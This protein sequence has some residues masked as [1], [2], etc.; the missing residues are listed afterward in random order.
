LLSPRSSFYLLASITISFRAASR[1]PTPLYP[2]YQAAWGF[3]ALTVTEIF[4]IYAIVLLGA[5]LVLGRLSDHLG[6]RPVL[7][8]ATLVQVAAVG[9]LAAAD[10][11]GMLLLGRVLQGLAA[12]AALGAVGAGML[13]IDKVRG[14][15]AN[16]VVPPL[17]TGTGGLMAG[18]FVH[19][20]PAPT[21]LVYLVL[22][23]VLLLQ[24]LGLF[25]MA[26]T[27]SPTGGAW[28]SLKPQLALPARARGP[29]L[30][31]AP[32]LVAVWAL[33]GFYGSLAPALMRK[34]MGLDPSLTSGLAGF[35]L[36]GSGAWAVLMLRNVEPRRVMALGA[37]VEFVGTVLV[38]LAFSLPSPVL[39]FVGSVLAGLGFGAGFQG[40][41]RTVVPLAQ[42]HERAGV[43]SIV[44]IISYLAMGLPAIVA[45]FFVARFGNLLGAAQVFGAGV[46]VLV[47]MALL[48]LVLESRKA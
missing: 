37:V 17:G 15:V 27:V 20:L 29:M 6:R 3:S 43:L 34:T 1:A 16:S 14:P 28:T 26:E 4:G 10:G 24:V 41:V 48:G 22:G 46:A 13:D 23:A 36:A 31:A 8:A 11:V 9:V 25:F 47:L 30:L 12:G 33:A 19:Y 44:F 7:I 38:V 21:H 18:L 42:P 39:F 35:V 32:M 45:G 40:A 2:V 5:L